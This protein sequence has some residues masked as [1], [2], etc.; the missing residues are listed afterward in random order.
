MAAAHT[1]AFA[2]LVCLTYVLSSWFLGNTQRAA[3]CGE[4]G[5]KCLL[6]GEAGKPTPALSRQRLPRVAALC[7]LTTA[8]ILHRSC[9]GP[10]APL[11]V[12]PL[13]VAPCRRSQLR[14]REM[15][16]EL[17]RN[18]QRAVDHQSHPA[19]CPNGHPL[20]A[21]PSQSAT[22]SLPRPRRRPH[23]LDV[24]RMRCHGVRPAAQHALRVPST[25]R[26]RCGSQPH[27]TDA[28][29]PA[30]RSTASLDGSGC[31]FPTERPRF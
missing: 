2:L 9:R 24:P 7:V 26:R 27:G 4:V 21:K 29:R 19:R 31:E 11:T 3:G 28:R 22:S 20:G 17:V 18:E 12:A 6:L 10:V 1:H 16:G 5:S 15:E 14:C 25:G 8:S 13:T 23:D 30:R